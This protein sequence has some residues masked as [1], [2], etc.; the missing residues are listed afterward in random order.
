MDEVSEDSGLRNAWNKLAQAMEHAEIFYTVEWAS[1][2]HHSYRGSLNPL[3]FLAYEGAALVGVVALAK[4]SSGDVVFLGADTGDYCE[5]VSPASLREV[6][7]QAVLAE[8]RSRG[9]SKIVL[10]NLPADSP[11][12]GAISS[13]ASQCN[14]H[15]HLR[16]AYDCARVVMGGA[17]ERVALKQSVLAKKRLRR[18]IRELKKRGPVHVVHETTWREIAP[19]LDLFFRAHVARFFEAGK[20]SNLVR[21]ERRAFLLE[22]AQTLSSS[23]WVTMSRLTV[24]DITAAWNYGFRF[25]GS[26][27]WY[28]PTVNRVYGD[29]SPG[30]CLL[31]K[32][33]ELSCDLPDV[34]VVDMGLGAEGYKERFATSTRQT[35]Y[36]ELNASLFQHLRTETRRHAASAVMASPQIERWIRGAVRRLLVA[37]SQI[38][39]NR[40][41]LGQRAFRR[42]RKSLFSREKVFFF[43]WPTEGRGFEPSGHTLVQLDSDLLGAAGIL[44]RD[45]PAALRF[46]IRSAQRLD[47]GVAANGFVLV[48]KDR[49]PLHFCW[50]KNFDGFTMAELDR[51]LQAPCENAVLIF[52]CFTPAAVRGCGYF[53]EAIALLADHLRSQGKSAWI[54]GA[55]TNKASLTGIRKTAFK[56]RFSL[57]RRNVLFLR[58]QDRFPANCML[59]NEDAAVPDEHTK[60]NS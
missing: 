53:S 21:D 46:L 33:V 39:G 55:E 31:A 18:N 1:A 41:N 37:R 2:V 50:V 56:Q 7:V 48:T 16:R 20:V 34:A 13:A 28:Q 54:F 17:E 40:K 9:V 58:V 22:L 15:I 11:T 47:S 27:F 12:V 59:S 25:G 42:V 26:W 5:F 44:Y 36:C 32:I 14:Y 45:D 10:T 60:V 6:F 30:Y 49:T 19:R 24:G 29:F 57:G 3:I 35:L 52:D 23:G 4:R 43:E 8:L 51:T 38:T